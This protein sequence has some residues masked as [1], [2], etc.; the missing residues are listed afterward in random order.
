MV[1][2]ALIEKMIQSMIQFILRKCY[3][4]NLSRYSITRIIFNCNAT[5]C[6]SPIVRLSCKALLH[7]SLWTHCSFH[8]NLYS[9]VSKSLGFISV[10]T[11]RFL[12]GVLVSFQCLG[13]LLFLC[14]TMY[15]HLFDILD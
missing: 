5:W 14:I 12:H 6:S 4:C 15:G 3:Q 11:L 1:R 8:G 7:F 2:A 9:L 13:V 10:M